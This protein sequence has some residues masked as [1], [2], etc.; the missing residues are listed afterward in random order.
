MF[1]ASDGGSPALSSAIWFTLHLEPRSSLDWSA[2][3]GGRGGVGVFL[4]QYLLLVLVSALCVALIAV[5][6]LT[7]WCLHCRRR[8]LQ[9]H[10]ERDNGGADKPKPANGEAPPAV[11]IIKLYQGCNQNLFIE[12]GRQKPRG[13]ANCK[14]ISMYIV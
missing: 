8:R 10:A 9:A 11:N 13:H 12:E 7:V 4:R 3:D 5:L 2:V 1:S 14:N 6:A